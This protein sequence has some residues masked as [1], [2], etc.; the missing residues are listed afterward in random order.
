[1]VA[2]INT[3]LSYLLLLVIVVCVAG[4]GIAIGIFLRKKKNAQLLE[5]QTEEK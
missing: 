2:F 5:E 3:F 4:I 1:M